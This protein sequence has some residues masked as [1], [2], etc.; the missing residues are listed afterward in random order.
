METDN[1]ADHE[2]TQDSANYIMNLNLAAQLGSSSHAAH[3]VTL[4][5]TFSGEQLGTGRCLNPG[6]NPG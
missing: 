2:S 4:S 3:N 1:A 6:C 5:R